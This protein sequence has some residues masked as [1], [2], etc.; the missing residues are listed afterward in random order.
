M[1]MGEKLINFAQI[2]CP[3]MI[4][5]LLSTFY[6]VKGL[7]GGKLYEVKKSTTTST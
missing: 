6:K 2:K 3:Q 5:W 1:V 4:L 7:W